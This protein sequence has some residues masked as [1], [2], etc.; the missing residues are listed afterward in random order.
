MFG[1]TASDLSGSFSYF[2]FMQNF[3][4]PSPDLM[5]ESWSLSVEEWFYVTL[6]LTFLVFSVLSSSK[7]RLILTSAIIYIAVFT[8]F[9]FYEVSANNPSWG[10]GIRR[11]VLLRLDSIGYGVLMAYMAFYHQRFMVKHTRLMLGIGICLLIPSVVLYSHYALTGSETLFNKTLL[12]SITNIGLALLLP[13]FSR[14]TCRNRSGVRIITYISITSYSMYLIHWSFALP[15]STRFLAPNVP[16][17]AAFC[18][19]FIL[20]T[21]L[22]ILVYKYFERP[23]TRLRD[24]F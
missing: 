6:P 19:Y 23:M 24:R 15:L 16:W 12:F 21:G 18:A 2:F 5:P 17:P 4:W 14:M 22:S 7:Q 13:W 8:V 1:Q 3:M 10:P 9:R 20:T 11:V